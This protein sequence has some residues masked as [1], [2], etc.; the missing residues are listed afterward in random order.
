M[1][2]TAMQTSIRTDR[3]RL[4][5]RDEG[6]AQWN[7]ELLG[8]HDGGATESV[9]DVRRRLAEQ[10]IQAQVNGIGLLTI[11]RRIDDEPMGSCGLI[12]GRCSLDEPEIVCELLTRFHGH[13][14]ATEAARAVM[15]AAFATGRHRIWSTVGEWNE[16]SLRVL[17]KLG[18]QR[19]RQSVDDRGRLLVYLVRHA[20][21]R[22]EQG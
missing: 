2:Y 16:P 7:H 6:D 12:V 11:R 9:Q 15:E 18:F 14:Y 4:R 17:N 5:L 19:H 13:G 3:L 20:Q 1:R 8:E 22:V 21:P 10:R